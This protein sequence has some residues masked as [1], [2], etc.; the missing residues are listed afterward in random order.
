M[1]LACFRGVKLESLTGGHQASRLL[2]SSLDRAVSGTE[3]VLELADARPIKNRRYGRL[4]IC[5]TSLFRS[6]LANTPF[7]EVLLAWDEQV[8]K[9]GIVLSQAAADT[10]SLRI[11][12]DDL[13]TRSRFE[14]KI[15][16]Y[17]FAVNGIERIS[18]HDHFLSMG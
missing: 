9:L 12:Y 1:I 4:Q 2:A 3:N 10:V 7:L 18:N 5:A 14:E 11:A 8:S 15:F 17:V 13:F 6:R 16:D